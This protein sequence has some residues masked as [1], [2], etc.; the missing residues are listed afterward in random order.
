MKHFILGALVAC[1]MGLASANSAQAGIIT[2]IAET[3]TG[4]PAR[5]EA[6]FND[7]ATPGSIEV[8]LKVIEPYLDGDLLG[9]FFNVGDDIS[10][11]GL[12]VSG[13]NI[14][15]FE[16]GRDSTNMAGSN[17]NSL[18]PI[19]GF[20]AA[21]QIGKQGAGGGDFFPTASFTISHT[22]ESL[23]LADI[24]YLT[25]TDPYAWFGVRLLSIDGS[26]SAKMISTKIP[27]SDPPTE[28]PSDPVPEPASLAIWSLLLAGG[29]LA[30]R[31]N[32]VQK[33]AALS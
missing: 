10:L 12:T 31:R 11:S 15:A 6:T 3:Y 33:V 1:S 2:S 25:K 17:A 18:N 14:T 27:D 19:E 24:S 29:G 23:T 4:T 32:R 8:S 9:F 16:T 22:T 20:D 7:V 5:V 26:G 28:P 30:Y 21:L 13:N